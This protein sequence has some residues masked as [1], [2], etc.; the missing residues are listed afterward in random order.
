MK[1]S[2]V[3][4]NGSGVSAEDPRRYNKALARAALT[5]SPT[6]HQR[7]QSSPTFLAHWRPRCAA[8]NHPVHTSVTIAR[9][10]IDAGNV[11]RHTSSVMEIDPAA[12]VQCS[13]RPQN[14]PQS[15]P[16]SRTSRRTLSLWPTPLDGG[17]LSVPHAQLPAVCASSRFRCAGL[18]M[19]GMTRS[20]KSVATLLR[21]PRYSRRLCRRH[22]VDRLERP[23][24]PLWARLE[25]ATSAGAGGVRCTSAGRQQGSSGI[26]RRCRLVRSSLW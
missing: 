7:D 23:A 5:P 26:W 24:H 15:R 14:D 8:G 25:T 3:T 6:R 1:F 17:Y 16:R 22:G 10:N 9:R 4:C 21:R 12:S 18:G 11:P 19:P 20:A 13:H 2:L